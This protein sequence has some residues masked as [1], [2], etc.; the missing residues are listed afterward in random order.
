MKFFITDIHGEYN[1]LEIL[2]KHA[3][4]DFTKDQLVFGGDYI[5]RGKDSGKVIRRIKELTEAYPNNVIA[6]IG[7]HEEMMRDYYRSGDK[8]WLSHGGRDTIREL[9]KTFPNE[10]ERNEHIEWACNLPLVYDEDDFV[11]TH[12]GLNPFEPLEKQSR[13]ILWMSES[14]FYSISKESLMNLTHDKPVVHGHTPVERI[15]FDG[16]R[17]NCDLGCNTYFIEEER[18]LALVELSRMIYYVYKQ[19]SGKIEKREIARF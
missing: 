12:A 5:N 11:Y 13:E 8:L 4:I 2:L 7:N 19:N 17:L 14:D 1:G 10:K 15:Y 18:G 9:E 3:E 6:L 16:V